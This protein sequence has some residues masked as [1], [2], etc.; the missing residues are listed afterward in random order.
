M[1]MLPRRAREGVRQAVRSANGVVAEASDDNKSVIGKSATTYWRTVLPVPGTES[2]GRSG[3]MPKGAI[4]PEPLSR[5]PVHDLARWC[6]NLCVSTGFQ[7]YIRQPRR[8][9]DF[10]DGVDVEKQEHAK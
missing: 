7:V 10:I 3:R 9:A 4:A 2:E 5:F 8:V 6:G 1:V